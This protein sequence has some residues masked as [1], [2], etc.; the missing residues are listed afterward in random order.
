MVETTATTTAT[1]EALYLANKYF[2][3]P[4][5]FLRDE[6]APSEYVLKLV[7]R[8]FEIM[9]QRQAALDTHEGPRV[10]DFIVRTDGRV[11]RFSHDWDECGLQTADSG[12]FYITQGGYASF[13]GALDPT[14]PRERI[15]PTDETRSGWVWFFSEDYVGAGR[16]VQCLLTFRVYRE[17]PG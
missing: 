14:L 12:S 2:Y 7:A 16:G 6:D 13:S 11:Q 4:A 9:Q 3:N 5:G 1:A 17:L 8:D 10:G 15:G